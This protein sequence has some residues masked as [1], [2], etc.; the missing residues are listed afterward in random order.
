MPLSPPN[1]GRSTRISEDERKRLALVDAGHQHR[2]ETRDAGSTSAANAGI[3]NS[4]GAGFQKL[5]SECLGSNIAGWIQAVPIFPSPS[6]VMKLGT[7]IRAIIDVIR[8]FF[9]VP[10]RFLQPE[11][12]M[13]SNFRL[14]SVQLKACIPRTPISRIEPGAVGCRVAEGCI[15]DS[16]RRN[17]KDQFPRNPSGN[18]GF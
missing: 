17:S 15:D 16:I 1:R 6:N 11:L 10:I 9:F 5:G 8:Y 13:V 12:L 18:S 14:G 2:P 7:E 3:D 4:C